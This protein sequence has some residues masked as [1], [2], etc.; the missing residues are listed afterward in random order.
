M[1]VK[2]YLWEFSIFFR[3]SSGDRVVLGG[4]HYFAFRSCV[5]S[6]SDLNYA[7]AQQELF[8]SQKARIDSDFEAR[9]E[10]TR[11]FALLDGHEVFYRMG[12]DSSYGLK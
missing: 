7:Q 11:C 12:S 6:Q 1:G 5:G 2:Y 10:R 8:E 9:T 3:L 4:S